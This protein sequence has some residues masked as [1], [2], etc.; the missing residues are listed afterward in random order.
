MGSFHLWIMLGMLNFKVICCFECTELFL[1]IAY[2]VV[3]KS[4]NKSAL[5]ATA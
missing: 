5:H 1:E 3:M 4:T 2:V